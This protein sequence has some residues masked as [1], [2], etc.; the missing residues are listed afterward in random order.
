MDDKILQVILILILVGLLIYSQ[1]DRKSLQC[2]RNPEREHFAAKKVVTA[3]VK[4][5]SG[6]TASQIANAAKIAAAQPKTV[7]EVAPAEVVVAKQVVVNPDVVVGRKLMFDDNNYFAK[8]GD[9]MKMTGK[10]LYVNRICVSDNQCIDAGNFDIVTRNV[11]NEKLKNNVYLPDE[12]MKF[13]NIFDAFVS[14]YI[15]RSAPLVN[16]DNTT[17]KT[18][19]WPENNLKGKKLIKFGGNNE[20]DGSG[21]IIRVPVEYNVVWV[22][23]LNERW[24]NMKATYVADGDVIGNYASGFRNLNRLAPD[25]GTND[26]LWNTFDWIPIPLADIKKKGS[27][28]LQ[29]P[30]NDGSSNVLTREVVEIYLTS[31]IGTTSDF[32]L[33][34]LA[35]STNPWNHT[36]VSAYALTAQVNG[37]DKINMHDNGGG[38]W[39]NDILGL[40]PAG[41]KPTFI[42]PVVD[43][44][45]DKLLYVLEHN[46]NW[47]GL[48]HTNIFVDGILIERLRTSYDNPI[49][50]HHSSKIYNRYA[51]AK[52]P[53]EFTKGKRWLKVTFDMTTQNNGL[54]IREIGTHDLSK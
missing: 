1:F 40:I 30:A 28:K 51:A 20:V 45:K 34:G 26:A 12:N 10:A 21:A 32:W 39:N 49:S 42:I 24:T 2:G 44:G 17:Y 43:S 3:V 4:N 15:A 37:G 46:N 53:A 9:N 54:Y 41:S 13:D 18:N 48:N 35:F 7:V 38:S 23:I 16:F 8:D 22:R 11:K 19:L 27:I 52:I 25:G 47:D 6:Q 14:G 5:T 31:K 50:R 33:A 29:V 36:F